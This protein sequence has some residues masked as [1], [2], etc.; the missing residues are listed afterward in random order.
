MITE[1]G[2][3][4]LPGDFFPEKKKKKSQS[5]TWTCSCLQRG[6]TQAAV[7]EPLLPALVAEGA[8]TSTSQPTATYGISYGMENAGFAAYPMYVTNLFYQEAMYAG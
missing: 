5:G 4:L 7:L 6:Q 2:S 3:I 1:L 8:S